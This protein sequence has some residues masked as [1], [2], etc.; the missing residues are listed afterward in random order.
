MMGFW[1]VMK[2]GGEGQSAS[3]SKRHETRES[4]VEE[5]LRLAEKEP[6]RTFWVL[7]LVGYAGPVSPAVEWRETERDF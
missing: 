1:A 2:A 7:E 6:G 4:A 5:A 3:F